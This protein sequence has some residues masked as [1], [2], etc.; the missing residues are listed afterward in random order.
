MRLAP[1]SALLLVAAL[2]LTA[3]SSAK[4]GPRPADADD[5]QIGKADAPITI[6]EYASASC[7]HCA[8]F[9]NEIFPL[10]KAKYVDTGQVHYVL[11][12][13]LTAPVAVAAAGFLTA[14]CAGN[15][16]AFNV[17]DAIY[18]DIAAIDGG[19]ARGALLRIAQSA[20]LSQ[21]QFETC[22]N[23]EKARKALDD[24]VA[25]NGKE[26]DVTGTPTFWINGVKLG[27]KDGG[28]QSLAQLDAAIA[29]VKAGKDPAAAAKAAEAVP[30]PATPAN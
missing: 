21:Q 29:A 2:A 4:K 19:D 16:K 9:N 17:L 8:Q 3:C 14:R 25:R 1:A 10:V 23:D 22:V 20:G 5:L 18:R 27:G 26:G 6:V 30:A 7:A 28:E 13:I 24:R 15:D 11:R 12:E